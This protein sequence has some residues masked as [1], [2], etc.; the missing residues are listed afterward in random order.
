MATIIGGAKRKSTIPNFSRTDLL[1]IVGG[2]AANAVAF[3]YALQFISSSQLI[4]LNKTNP[5]FLALLLYF[6]GQERISL[7]GLAAI[8]STV[9]GIYVLVGGP[10]FEISVADGGLLGS[11]LA[12]LAGVAFAVFTFGLYRNI[13]HQKEAAIADRLWYMGWV[14]LWSYLLLATAGLLIGTKLPADA[15][16]W[17]W[18]GINGI[19]IAVV[20][21]IYQQAIRLTDPILVSVVVSLEVL[22]TILLEQHWLSTP[23]TMN[24]V[25]GAVLI[26]GAIW[27]LILERRVT[28]YSPKTTR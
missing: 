16:S 12:L 5:L 17:F 27:S 20:Y 19:R 1:F 22:F 28:Q 3:I 15:E 18:I 13:E 21:L 6:A 25:L 2:N 23:I 26:L 14:L 24:V 9:C 4:I 7:A 8:V 11:T 10:T